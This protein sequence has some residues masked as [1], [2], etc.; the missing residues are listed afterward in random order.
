PRRSCP[1]H[2]PESRSRL[3]A[4][5]GATAKNPGRSIKRRSTARTV[6]ARRP[7]PRMSLPRTEDTMRLPPPA[8]RSP[9]RTFPRGAWALAL[10]LA[11]LTHTAVAG[12]RPVLPANSP[13]RNP[14]VD[15]VERVRDCVVNIHS[16]R[17]VAA[18][19]ADELFTLA[20]SPSR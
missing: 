2:P 16:E 15:V 12:E 5:A 19:T 11:A 14:I 17:N 9:R 13:R 8:G 6:V 7:P 3:I 1:T 20:P 4:T 10:G 18:P